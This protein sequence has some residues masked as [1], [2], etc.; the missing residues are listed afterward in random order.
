MPAL[1]RSGARINPFRNLFHAPKLV[2]D[3]GCHSGRHFQA[4]VD[5]DEVI[6]RELERQR[7]KVIVQLFAE[8]I[9]QPRKPPH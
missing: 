2:R 1:L 5:A 6:E 8:C 7:I 3:P 4:L 9:R